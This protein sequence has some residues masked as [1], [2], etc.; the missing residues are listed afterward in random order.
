MAKLISKTYGDALL[1]I[2]GEEN[3]VDLLLEEVTAV[4][5]ILKDNPEFSKL[6]NN[7]RISVDEKQTVMSN[8]FEGRIS[9][10]LMGF[11]SMIVNKGRYDHIDEI[12]T[13]FQDEVKKIKG[14][15]VAYVTTP[16]ELSDTQKKNVEKKLLETAG[17]KQMEMHYDIDTELVGGMR[18]RIGDRVVDSSIHTKILKMQQDMMKVMV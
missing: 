15:G 10:E 9:N 2:A 1:E 11:F 12:L 6:M 3:K 14:I 17:F 16:L 13:Y 8:V 7:P 4:M 5:A 18:I